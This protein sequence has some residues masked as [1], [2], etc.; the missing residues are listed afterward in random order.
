MRL[1]F[2]FIKSTEKSFG[3]T[4][5]EA[6]GSFKKNIG[7]G[8]QKLVHPGGKSMTKKTLPFNQNELKGIIKQYPTPFYIYDEEAIRKNARRLKAS[9]EWQPRQFMNFF[10][11]KALPNPY[12][13]KILA[14]EGMGAD[15]SSMAEL[16]LAE[17][18]GIKGRNIMFTSNDTP[19]VE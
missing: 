6:A 13:L 14:E 1:C 3:R 15:C 12:I 17:K 16:I 9:F 19:L 4:G 7:A 18:A 10:A 2:R 8:I 5:D 11:V